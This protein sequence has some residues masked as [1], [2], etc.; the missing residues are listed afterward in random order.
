MSVKPIIFSGPMVRAIRDGRKS[1]TRRVVKP[2][3]DA[4]EDLRILREPGY[5][6]HS[7]GDTLWV[8]EAWA[9]YLDYAFE[10]PSWGITLIVPMG[11]NVASSEGTSTARRLAYC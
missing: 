3:P 1:V 11:K 2:Q 5:A 4:P 6:P 9:E 7:P 10:R 8:Q